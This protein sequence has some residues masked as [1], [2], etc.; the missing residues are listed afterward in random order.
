[1]PRC[2][3]R[4][5]EW[6]LESGLGLMLQGTPNM[7]VIDLH[8]LAS[9]IGLPEVQAMTES[10]LKLKHLGQVQ[11]NRRRYR[12]DLDDEEENEG[13]EDENEDEEGEEGY[14]NEDETQDEENTV[15]ESQDTTVSDGQ[16][17]VH[18]SNHDAEE[19]TA[20]VVEDIL[21][22]NWTT[23]PAQP[24]VTD[25]GGREE[26]DHAR[27]LNAHVTWLQEQFSA[28][29]IVGS[30]DEDEEDDDEYWSQWN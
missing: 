12:Q 3:Q 9:R 30:Y 13:E 27:M 18:V 28:L 1:M 11:E 6:S 15:E 22:P 29:E 21:V 4:S 19:P 24:T 10:W 23:S 14:E 17:Q 20:E 5:L 7:E 2:Q 26:A 8:Q 25:A 16:E